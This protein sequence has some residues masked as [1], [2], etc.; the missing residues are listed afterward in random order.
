MNYYPRYPAHYMAKTLH[1]TME[2]DGA[3][4]RLMDWCYANERPI[5]HASRYAIARASKASEKAAVDAV[6]AEFFNDT[7]D[8]WT[9]DRIEKEIRKAAPKIEAAKENGRKGGRPRKGKPT[10][11]ISDNPLGFENVTQTEPSENPGR[12]L[13]NPQSPEEAINLSSDSTHG[14]ATRLAGATDAGRACLLMRQAGCART[15]PGHEAL[16]QA[17][18]LGV[19]PETL[20]HTAAEA[21]DLGKT[22]PFAWAISAAVSRHQQAAQQPTGA[23]HAPRNGPSRPSLAER[24]RQLEAEGN[25]RDGYGFAAGPDDD[26]IP[27]EAIRVR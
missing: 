8:G 3:Y 25:A 10:G 24:A 13:P 9:N 12:K 22:N 14:S 15:N 4:T 21:V 20:G 18:A 1:L 26:A 7:G 17:L 19:T 5:P 27:G 16:R 23:T 2:Q 11:F 6:L